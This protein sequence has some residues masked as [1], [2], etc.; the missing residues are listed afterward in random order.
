[1]DDVFSFQSWGDG[2]E[3][4]KV[5]SFSPACGRSSLRRLV[6]RACILHTLVNSSLSMLANGRAHHADPHHHT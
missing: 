4:A 5:P 1:M 3:E 6:T 2:S